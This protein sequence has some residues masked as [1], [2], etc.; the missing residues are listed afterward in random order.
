MSTVQ[1]I[2]DKA[3]TDAKFYKSLASDFESAI[4]PFRLTRRE[5]TELKEGLR[6]IKPPTD[7][8]SFED[9]FWRGE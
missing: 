7:A 5:V 3:K 9:P 2:L 1:T 8:I 6:K 4:A